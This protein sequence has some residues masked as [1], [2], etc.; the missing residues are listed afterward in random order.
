MDYRNENLITYNFT[1]NYCMMCYF[2]F[3]SLITISA[4]KFFYKNIF[5]TFCVSY[6]LSKH[7]CNFLFP[8]FQK[9]DPARQ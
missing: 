9:D 7:V 2:D 4:T 5:Q 6:T 3:V 8:S 1:N